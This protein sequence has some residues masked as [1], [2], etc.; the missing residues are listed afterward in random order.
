MDSA[1]HLIRAIDF[2][3]ILQQKMHYVGV[4]SARCPDDWVDTVLLGYTDTQKDGERGQSLDG[5]LQHKFTK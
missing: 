5:H 3:T 4:A 2:R 1:T